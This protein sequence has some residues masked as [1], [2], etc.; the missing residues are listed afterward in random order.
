MDVRAKLSRRSLCTVDRRG[1]YVG[2]PR[3]AGGFLW[4][5]TY[6]Q[7]LTQTNTGA[8]CCYKLAILKFFLD[9]WELK[10]LSFTG[11]PLVIST[12]NCKLQAGFRVRLRE[13]LPLPMECAGVFV[14]TI[15]IK[16]SSSAR[17]P[18][19]PTF[20]CLPPSMPTSVFWQLRYSLRIDRSRSLSV[21]APVF[22]F[23]DLE[24]GG[25]QPTL[26]GPL[27]SLPLPFP[28]HSP[29]IPSPPTP[30]PS[31]PLRSRPPFCG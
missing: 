4:P 11:R 25:C 14:S 17:S 26:G 30:F 18:A 31:L 7:C 19:P 21:P 1:T 9:V 24:H 8:R 13:P 10:S 29:P 23:Q 12:G 15:S 2:G 20:P 5:H 6:A 28:F 22:F 27:P 3:S 16:G